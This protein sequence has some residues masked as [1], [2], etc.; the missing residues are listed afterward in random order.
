MK[1]AS[2][3]IHILVSAP[4]ARPSLS[5]E[6]SPDSASSVLTNILRAADLRGDNRK[7]E[8]YVAI[9][10]QTPE[11]R[12]HPVTRNLHRLTVEVWHA[13]RTNPL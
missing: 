1:L 3:A 8:P 7:I 9:P 4:P 12:R 13:C 5:E 2:T 11:K 6:I 10:F